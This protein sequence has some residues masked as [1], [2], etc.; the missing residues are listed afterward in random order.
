[1]DSGV[2]IAL[3]KDYFTRS[4]VMSYDF[5]GHSFQGAFIQSLEVGYVFEQRFAL[6]IDCN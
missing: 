4:V 5:S 2:R 6:G 3:P 1:M